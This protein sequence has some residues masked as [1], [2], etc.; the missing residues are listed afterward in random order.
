[1]ARIKGAAIV[2]TVRFLR[3]RKEEARKLLPA[4][5]HHYLAERVLIASWYPEEDLIPLVRAMARVL[6]EPERAFFDKAG[7]ISART[8]A[9]GV[10]RHLVRP[11]ERESLARRA[12][13]LWSSQHDTGSMEMLPEAPGQ[14]RVV[15]R[16]F[17][18][19]SRELCV[20]NGG[21]VA[22]T[23]EVNGCHEVRVQK[24]SCCMD[25]APECAW[26][27]SWDAKK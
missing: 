17:G 13:V 26:L 6:G 8:H 1:V 7:R 15:V 23:F 19:P 27:V 3:R 4:E 22:G 11:G 10:Y 21:Y 20:I 16:D 14:V 18:A 24:L 9:Q 12:L 2:D 5:L 25:G